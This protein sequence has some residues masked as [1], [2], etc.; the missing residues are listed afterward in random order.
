MNLKHSLV[1][2]CQHTNSPKW[3]FVQFDGNSLEN[4]DKYQIGAELSWCL[5]RSD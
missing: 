4:I 2:K 3:F 1:S 5:Q